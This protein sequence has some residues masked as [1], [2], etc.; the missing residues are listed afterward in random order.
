MYQDFKN[1]FKRIFCPWG[2][3]EKIESGVIRTRTDFNSITG[4]H[5]TNRVIVDVFKRTH[6][7]NG[8]VQHKHVEWK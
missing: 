5:S 3:W 1:L 4:F 8:V 2:K 7:F 6:L